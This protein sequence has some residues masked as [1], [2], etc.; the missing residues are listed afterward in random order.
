MLDRKIETVSDRSMGKNIKYRLGS[1]YLHGEYMLTAFS[2]FDS[3]NRA[4]LSQKEYVSCMLNFWD[5]V[6]QLYAGRSVSVPLM[7]SGITRFRDADVQPQ[8][9]LKILIW[10]YKISRVKFKHPA[11][12]TIIIHS[13][14]ADKINLYELDA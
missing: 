9:L 8:E 7:G 14:M 2:H 12:V 13:S 3:Q 5:E 4:Y 10:S 11:N 1:V 6:D